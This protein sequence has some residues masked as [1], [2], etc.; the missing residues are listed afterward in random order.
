MSVD[1]ASRPPRLS[2]AEANVKVVCGRYSV[3]I[4]PADLMDEFDIDDEFEG[5]PALRLQRGADGCRAV[6]LRAPGPRLVRCF[7]GGPRVVPL[8][9]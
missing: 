6:D 2:D 1:T 7:F 3:S 4:P 9:R 5:L 8:A